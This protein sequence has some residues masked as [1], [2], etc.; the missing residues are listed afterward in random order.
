M[1]VLAVP[2]KRPERSK[3]RLSPVLSS[4]ER[5][6]L[7]VAM[8]EDVLDAAL[9][10]RGWDVWVV[11]ASE[12]VLD[13][14]ARR[15]ARPVRDEAATLQG[16]IR[17]VEGTMHPK[18][19]LA[20][21]LGDCPLVTPQALR[22]AFARP[23]PVVAVR[24]ASDGGTNLL[25]RRP[26]EC[27]PARFGRSSF[28]RHRAEAHRAGVAFGEPRIPELAFD[29]DRPADLETVLASPG[30]TRTRRACLDMGLQDRLRVLA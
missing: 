17:Q 5:A 2:V 19:R 8:L 11:S 22:A 9:V 10:Q 12:A 16:A 3:R 20:V 18:G 27:I 14:A 13:V 6:A 24:A 25:V 26:P 1:R 4:L 30:S 29:L 23:E 28:R 21:L 15:G 7:T